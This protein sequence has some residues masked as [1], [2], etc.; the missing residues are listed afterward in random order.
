MEQGRKSFGQW[1]LGEGILTPDQ[2]QEALRSQSVYGGRLGTNLVEIGYLG[3]DELAEDLTRFHGL[4]L[5]PVQWL[6]SPEEKAIKLVPM[7]LIR[8][9]KLLPMHLDPE[10][11][12]VA[13]LDPDDA[14]QLDF[15]ETAACRRVVPYVL[16]EIRL[17][18]WLET[19]LQIDRHPRYVNLAARLR[20]TDMKLSEAALSNLGQTFD[21]DGTAIPDPA[22]PVEVEP[23]PPPDVLDQWFE[24]DVLRPEP[25]PASGSETSTPS[26]AAP[27]EDADEILLLEEL[28]VDVES[29]PLPEPAASPSAG[30]LTPARVAELEARLLGASERDAIVE[31]VLELARAYCEV[32]VLFLVHGGKVAPLRASGADVTQRLGGLE[33]PLGMHSIFAHPAVTGFAFRGSP[34]EGGIDGRLL[35]ALGRQDVHDLLV[36]PIRIGER[37][38]NLLYCDNGSSAFG[39]SGVAALG[40]VADCAARAYERLILDRKRKRGD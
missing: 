24:D 18:Y 17:L 39:E 7:A 22:D 35:E 25:A 12:H 20:R 33:V 11:I 14:E 15:V 16:P 23:P 9:L 19:H 8:R 3:L 5:A 27:G 1:L 30:P 2:L 29:S 40:A 6:E 37:V 34:P 10:A 32:A 38:V 21:Q 26:P 13:M 31:G 4:P 28:A 36:Q